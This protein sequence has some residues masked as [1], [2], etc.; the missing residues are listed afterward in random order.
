MVAKFFMRRD[1]MK[2][3]NRKYKKNQKGV[4]TIDFIFSFTMVLGLFQIFYVLSYTLMVAHL[5]QYITFSS[6]RLFFAG[7]IKRVDQKRLA[8]EKFD[9]LS[10]TSP[11]AQFYKKQFILENLEIKEFKEYEDTLQSDLI[12]INLWVFE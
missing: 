4:L 3:T 7:H 5:T 1:E 12:V 9:Y 8:Q 2:D 10:K 6:A 11:V